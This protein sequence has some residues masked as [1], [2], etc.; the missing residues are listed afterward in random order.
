MFEPSW[1]KQRE[2]QQQEQQE[3][4]AEEGDWEVIRGIEG[5]LDMV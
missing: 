1:G 4:Y 3:E 2:K 5:G